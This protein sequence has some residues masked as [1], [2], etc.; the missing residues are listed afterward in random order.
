MY[1]DVSAEDEPRGSATGGT[2]VSRRYGQL[3]RR[4]HVIASPVTL[5]TASLIGLICGASRVAAAQERHSVL[6]RYEVSS[7]PTVILADDG[8]P[9]RQFTRVFVRRMPS[10]RLVVGEPEAGRIRIFGRDGRVAQVLARKGNGPGELPGPF[11]LSSF[12]DTVLAF[13]QPPFSPAGVYSFSET[14]GYAGQLRPDVFGGLS[15]FVV[16]RL[17]S[18]QYLVRR[19]SAIRGVLRA[20]PETGKLFP[21]SVTYGVLS[22]KA[23]DSATVNWLAPVVQQWSFAHPWPGGPLA[24]ALSPY[25]FAPRTF[26]VASGDR[27]WVVAADDGTL[28][29][30]E[31][32]GVSAASTRLS[33]SARPFDAR[34]LDARLTESLAEAIRPLDSARVI[35]MFDRALLP[36]MMPLVS[37]AVPGPDGEIWLR[38]FNPA[39]TAPQEFVVV[40]RNG[41]EIAEALVPPEVEVQQVGSDFLVGVRTLVDGTLAIVEFALRR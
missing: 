29:S 2:I 32:T 24:T 10:G 21:D 23:R 37:A 20:A 35:A 38:R 41:R 8:S 17:L 33:G 15:V 7:A 40:D 4:W 28:R 31:P 34:S 22:F 27:F 5:T 6:R 18:G 14:A 12:R 25:L 9:E 26:V 30:Y 11:T 19:G 39:L 16:D 3:F 13:G 1:H 36:P